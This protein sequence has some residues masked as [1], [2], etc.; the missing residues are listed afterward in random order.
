MNFL[1]HPILG[2]R[3]PAG[4]GPPVSVCL[5]GAGDCKCLRSKSL[6]VTELLS[7]HARRVNR[8]FIS[9]RICHRE[10]LASDILLLGGA[11]SAEWGTLLAL[12]LHFS[13]RHSVLVC[14]GFISVLPD[15][16][17]V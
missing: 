9:P 7:P 4:P 8:L 11:A 2:Y 13:S 1:K 12:L 17:L 3:I 14:V 5:R 16:L 6:C 10:A 15:K